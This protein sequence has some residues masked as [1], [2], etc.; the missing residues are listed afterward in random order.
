MIKITVLLKNFND[1]LTDVF[2][3]IKDHHPIR[4]VLEPVGDVHHILVIGKIMQGPE[5]PPHR[6]RIFIPFFIS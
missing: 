6:S 4:V 5:I 2:A 1:G 3:K